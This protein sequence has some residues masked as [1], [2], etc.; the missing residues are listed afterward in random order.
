MGHQGIER[1][2]NLIRER[3]FWVG[4]YDDIESWVKNCQRCILT[5]MPQPKIQAPVKAFLASRLLE[6]V[7]VDFTVLEK[8]SDGRENV[9]VITDVFTKFTQAYPTREEG[10]VWRVWSA[11][12]ITL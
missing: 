7:A 11:G 9:L 10:R 6:V 4:M 1:T 12:E 5:K 3:C 8:A 2:V